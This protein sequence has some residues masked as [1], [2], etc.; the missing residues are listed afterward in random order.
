MG[1]MA[2]RLCPTELQCKSATQILMTRT[3]LQHSP[4]RLQEVPAARFPPNFSGFPNCHRA[5]NLFAAR[6]VFLM[7]Q[8]T[9]DFCVKVPFFCRY[10]QEN[11]YLCRR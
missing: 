11:G 8:E 7:R 9:E 10:R 2:L 1:G 6:R 4:Y 5:T 3:C